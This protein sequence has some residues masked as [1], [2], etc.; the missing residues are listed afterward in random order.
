VPIVLIFT[1][2]DRKGRNEAKSNQ[3]AYDRA[4]REFKLSV[5]QQF[6]TSA[7]D[8]TGREEILTWMEEVLAEA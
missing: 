3:A 2:G 6:M 1:K 5:P 7:S 8:K 4:L